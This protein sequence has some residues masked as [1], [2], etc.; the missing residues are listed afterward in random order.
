MKLCKSLL[1]DN[2]KGEEMKNIIYKLAEDYQSIIMTFSNVKNIK[3]I[4]HINSQILNAIKFE[5]DY[6][7]DMEFSRFKDMDRNRYLVKL[8][9]KHKTDIH[10]LSHYLSEEYGYL[11]YTDL[12][13]DLKINDADVIDWKIEVM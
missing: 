7:S 9:S 10:A 1:G 11:G 4:D 13:E 2:E 6:V 8:N 12:D 5:C 3:A